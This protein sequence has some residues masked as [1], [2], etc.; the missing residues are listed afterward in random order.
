[1]LEP[2]HIVIMAPIMALG[3]LAALA[4][5]TRRYLLALRDQH[6]L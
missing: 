2:A 6:G 1:V 3:V 5:W 4:A